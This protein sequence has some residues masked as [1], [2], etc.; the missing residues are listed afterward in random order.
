MP[1]K[2]INWYKLKVGPSD[3]SNELPEALS[4]PHLT[5]GSRRRDDWY[6]P[7]IEPVSEASLA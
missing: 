5:S 1:E 7:K 4:A 2:G 3:R 6:D